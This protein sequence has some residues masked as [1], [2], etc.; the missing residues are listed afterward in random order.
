MGSG[1]WETVF[2]RIG[3]VGGF[4]SSPRIGCVEIAL[5]VCVMGIFNYEGREGGREEKLCF[6][7]DFLL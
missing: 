2:Q 6:R 7:L 5:Y 3:S 1:E 4:C